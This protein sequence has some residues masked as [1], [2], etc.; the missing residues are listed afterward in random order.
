MSDLISRQAALDA[1][2]WKWAGKAAFDAIKA[3]PAE[4]E[5]A[6]VN[7]RFV[8]KNHV[9]INGRQFISLKRVGEMIEED[10][11]KR[12]ER[13]KGKWIIGIKRPSI[14]TQ[15]DACGWAWSAN[16]DA[17]KLEPCLAL[18][19]TR[20]CPNCGAEMESEE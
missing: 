13:P 8:D 2:E 16:I 19:K 12:P 10:R 20:Y 3:L 6:E 14:G 18:I 1:I 11:K 9:W 5:C 17:V 7:F 4:I 15:C